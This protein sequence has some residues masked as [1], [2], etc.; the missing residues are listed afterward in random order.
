MK[1]IDET[2]KIPGISVL[3]STS[4]PEKDVTFINLEKK[5][6]NGITPDEISISYHFHFQGL[7]LFLW[8]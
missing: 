1:V 7:F 5:C 2:K 4:M 8:Y 3:F 6:G